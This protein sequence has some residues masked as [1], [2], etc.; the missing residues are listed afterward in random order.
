[1]KARAWRALGVSGGLPKSLE[2]ERARNVEVIIPTI[3]LDFVFPVFTQMIEAKTVGCRVHNIE[4]F[5]PEFHELSRIDKA[6]KNGSLYA[7]AI[8][9]TGFGN[10]AEA[11]FPRGGGCGDVVGYEEVHGE[12][13][14]YLLRNAG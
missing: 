13:G 1:M 9:E 7:L 2:N 12:I 11:V 4:K 5:S 10:P 6:F 14:C 3:V 8:I